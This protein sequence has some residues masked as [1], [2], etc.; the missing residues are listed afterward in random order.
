MDDDAT[1]RKSTSNI[2]RGRQY[3]EHML[4]KVGHLSLD[5]LDQSDSNAFVP[6]ELS[7]MLDYLPLEFSD[8]SEEKYINALM[9]AA[10]TSC[11]NGLFQFAYV[12]YH[13]LF[14]TAVYYAL[15][16]RVNIP[17]AWCT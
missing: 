4:E 9:L 1:E 13:M 3:V 12:Q 14:M 6:D 2:E 17:L 16:S 11:E 8:E 5:E 15:V 10:R 7:I